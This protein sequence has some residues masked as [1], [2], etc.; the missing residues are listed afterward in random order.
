MGTGEVTVE[1]PDYPSGTRPG[2]F[3]S[4]RIVTQRNEGSLLVD[5]RAVILD[6]GERIVYVAG[7]ED[8]AERRVV[9]VGFTDDEHAE[10]LEGVSLGERVVVKGQR[11]L[12]PGTPLKILSSLSPKSAPLTARIGGEPSST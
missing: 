12:K 6:R 10:I 3:A 9:S 7:E 11:S 1:I 4:L 5:R 8:L 2:D